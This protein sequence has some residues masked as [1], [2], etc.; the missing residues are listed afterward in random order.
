MSD[1]PSSRTGV[2]AATPDDAAAV[3]RLQSEAWR[4]AYADLLPADV[5][6]GAN[7]QAL[8]ATWAET[9]AQP[10]GRLGL[11]L[12]ALDAGVRVG[13]LAAT[14]ASDPDL[15]AA[16]D[17]ELTLLVVGPAARGQ[18]HGT[19]LTTAAVELLRD[20]GA[21]TLVMWVAEADAAVQTFLET[22][23]WA[24]DGSRRTLDLRGDG[25][26]VVAQHRL[27]TALT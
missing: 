4:E 11:V 20:A 9:L 10:L 16:H 12:L 14:V 24:A 5:L 21:R 17:A 8:G 1:S 25:T 3:G 6:A 27:H 7:A 22:T 19:R 15:D 26:T 23:G 2:R 13:V 18:G